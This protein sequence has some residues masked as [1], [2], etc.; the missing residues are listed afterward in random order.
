MKSLI[1]LIA[2]I[3]SLS[4]FASSKTSVSLNNL[5]T[6]DDIKMFKKTIN[7]DNHA[8]DLN[9]PYS[10]Q[11]IAWLDYG[12]EIQQVSGNDSDEEFTA[13]HVQTYLGKQLQQNFFKFTVGHHNLKQNSESSMM[14]Y[15]LQYQKKFEETLFLDFFYENDWSYKHLILP[16]GVQQ[17]LKVHNLGTNLLL[18][19]VPFIRSTMQLLQ[20]NFSD[21]NTKNRADLAIMYGKAFPLWIWG[22]YGFEYLRNSQKNLDYWSPDK[23]IS[24]RLQLEVAK[25]FKEK[26]TLKAGGSY[27]FLKEEEG[28]WSK[29]TYASLALEYGDRNSLLV[30]FGYSKIQAI[31]DSNPWH[32]N[33]YALN[34]NYLF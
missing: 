6:S 32:M 7:Y 19:P 1:Y 27:S 26:W 23:M 8:M 16:G 9:W 13:L 30:S 18:T 21:G 17:K 2:F 20:S 4:S 28:E 22:G 14:T 33:E 25:S 15:K 3:F 11:G 34:L 12:I 31:Q 29:S 24:H 5:E 10:S